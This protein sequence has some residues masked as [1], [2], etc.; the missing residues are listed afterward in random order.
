M[1]SA[2]AWLGH[3]SVAPFST[4]SSGFAEVFGKVHCR[5]R[6]SKGLQCKAFAGLS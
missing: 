3:V 1:E 5:Y 4:Y 6:Q 2:V